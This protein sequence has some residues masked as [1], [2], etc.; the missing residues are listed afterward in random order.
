MS[1][2]VLDLE[3]IPSLDPGIMVELASEIEPD[4]NLK[5]PEKIQANVAKKL[6]KA[7]EDTSL[8]PLRGSICAIG[9]MTEKGDRHIFPA[10]A[11]M[12][13]EAQLKAEERAIRDANEVLSGTAVAWNGRDFDF[14][15]M[16]IRSLRLPPN[17]QIRSLPQYLMRGTDPMVKLFGHRGYVKQSTFAKH[18]GIPVD[19]SFDGSMVA[20]AYAR[21][22]YSKITDHLS[23]DI[24]VLWE[25]VKRCEE[26]LW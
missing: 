9:V 18:L 7:Y 26:V 15:F 6:K 21:G 14:R 20:A 25:I 5:D 19:T 8:D 24:R 2:C 3:T 22:E 4:K 10:Y 23:D 13:L 11:G 16:A 12:D 17:P 1:W